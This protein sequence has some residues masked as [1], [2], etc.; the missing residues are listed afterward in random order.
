MP[1]AHR[2]VVFTGP[3]KTAK[4]LRLLHAYQAYCANQKRAKIIAFKPQADTRYNDRCIR[5]RLNPDVC[6]PAEIVGHSSEILSHVNPNIDLVL[7]DEANF[8]DSDL[9]HAVMKVR[10]QAEVFITGLDK[11][12]RGL[13]FGPMGHLLAIANEVHKLKAYCD[14]CKQELAEYTQLLE[15]GRP[16]SAFVD[17]I[18]PEG[19]VKNRVYETRC[20]EHFEPPHDLEEWLATQRATAV[21][22]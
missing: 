1:K 8:F 12:F 16:A 2:I 7:I 9:L 5:T 22:V 4:T 17:T 11:D 15:D 19:S 6:I 14:V 13:P 21:S 20:Q 10:T 18:T 3:M